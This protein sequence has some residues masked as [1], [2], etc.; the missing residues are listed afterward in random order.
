MIAPTLYTERLTLRPLV[1]SDFA[2]IAAMYQTDRAAFIG[3]RLPP[4]RVWH[5]FAS[6][7]GS[8]V[9]QG[10]G[11][12]AVDLA[13]GTTVGQVGLTRPV[14]HPEPELGWLLYDGFE[15]QGDATEAATAARDHGFATLGWPT[16]VSYIDP[17]NHPSQAVALRLG[18]ARDPEAAT[19]G[20]DPTWVYRTRGG[21]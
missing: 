19:P 14:H 2:A 1:H 3:G 7:V 20:T 5:G 21:Q 9:L 17:V 6:D 16:F 10:C 15:R 13:D 8:W 12:W 18:G 11:G 4:A